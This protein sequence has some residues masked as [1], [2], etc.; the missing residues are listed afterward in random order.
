MKTRKYYS[1]LEKV[2]DFCLQKVIEIEK[3]RDQDELVDSKYTS[4]WNTCIAALNDLEHEV[5]NIKLEM[6]DDI[7][8][9]EYVDPIDDVMLNGIGLEIFK[10]VRS[11]QLPDL[12][13]YKCT[14]EVSAFQIDH[15]LKHYSDD[16]EELVPRG[17]GLTHFC[18]SGK[19]ARKYNPKAGGY[20]V[21]YDD[22][23]E[24]C[25]DREEFEKQFTIINEPRKEN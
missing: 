1:K 21:R 7:K 6:R 11:K 4:R 3:Y 10:L 16:S 17:W 22:G 20:F 24:V 13:R 15:V 19:F 9:P 14:T 5:T 23:S 12:P 18:V 8:G 25:M 2:C